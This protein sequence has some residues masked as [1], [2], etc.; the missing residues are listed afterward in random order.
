MIRPE[1]KKTL[2]D[3]QGAA[4]I[5]WGFFTVSI[6]L[7]ILIAQ[8]VLASRGVPVDSNVGQT[9]RQGLWLL[10][11][12]DLGYLVWWR[13]RYLT[14]QAMFDIA[15]K[16]KTLRALEEHKTPAERQAAFVVSTYVTRKIVAFAI[17]EAVAVY[18]LVVALVGRYLWDQYLLS[19]LSFVL[20]LFEFPSKSFLEGLVNE[21]EAG[22]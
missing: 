16:T 22:R 20:L 19:G 15:A 3:Q 5:L 7:Y 6:V 11:L 21:I 10:V 8:F 14:R 9:L 4:V 17:I 13:K 12:V 2:L 18:G 1:F